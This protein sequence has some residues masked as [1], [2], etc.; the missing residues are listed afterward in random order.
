[1]K[2]YALVFMGSLYTASLCAMQENLQ[3]TSGK[4]LSI[5]KRME[6]L[7]AEQQSIQESDLNSQIK[8][9][10]DYKIKAELQRLEDKIKSFSK[11]VMHDEIKKLQ[12]S[13]QNITD[14]LE[15]Q[16]EE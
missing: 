6:E 2:M 12:E 1:M 3:V 7:H 8:N 15:W 13:C 10:A 9:D 5:Q 14:S 4:I 16:I 11:I